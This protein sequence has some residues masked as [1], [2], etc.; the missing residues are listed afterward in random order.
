MSSTP[1]SPAPAAGAVLPE[2]DFSFDS[3]RAVSHAMAPTVRL[4]L[5]VANRGDTEV[6]SLLLD[7]QVRIAPR[8][9]TYGED[10]EARL[11]DLFGSRE[12]WGASMQGLLW[13]STTL[14]VP[15]LE[16]EAV[17]ELDLGCSYDFEVSANR[18]LAAL[19]DGEIPIEAL[20]SGTV[21]YAGENGR[22]QV[23]RLPLDR[24]ASFGL[25]VAEWRAAIDR[26][27]PGSAWMRLSRESFD[28]LNAYRS[29]RML[30]SWEAVVDDLLAAR[31]EGQR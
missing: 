4:D 28:R 12:Q 17:V 26:H 21:F 23:A 11:I 1:E 25:P 20:F 7:T 15:R 3:A 22:P 9:R 27:F 10:E 13:T 8:R 2:L 18:Y 31:E 6:H 19:E 30:A 5:R 14:Y 16:E 24:E 29:Q